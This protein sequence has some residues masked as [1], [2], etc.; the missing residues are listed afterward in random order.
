MGIDKV[1]LCLEWRIK[2]VA[3]INL[4]LGG[5]RDQSIDDIVDSLKDTCAPNLIQ[6]SIPH[7]K[8]ELLDLVREQKRLGGPRYFGHE[9]SD[10][11]DIWSII[12]S[13]IYAYLWER[14]EELAKAIIIATAK[15]LGISL[16]EADNEGLIG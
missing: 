11:Q 13:A 14:F 7:D 15:E 10:Y 5:W 6:N 16:K 1:E 4:E 8:D 12:S 3:R 2:D 9:F